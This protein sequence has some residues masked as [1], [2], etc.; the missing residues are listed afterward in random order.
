MKKKGTIASLFLLTV[1]LSPQLLHANVDEIIIE[2][3]SFALGIEASEFNITNVK[4]SGI[5][6]TYSVS[7]NRGDYYK[8]Y[9]ASGAG[10]ISDAVCSYFGNKSKK[11]A[12]TG[13]VC[14][15]LLKA[16]RRC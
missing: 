12:G 5:K 7:T 15:E 2:N 9:V 8:C 14:N 16:A 13:V 10:V 11:R 3:T 1:G 6:T 4:K